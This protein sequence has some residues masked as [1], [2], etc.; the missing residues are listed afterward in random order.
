MCDNC[1]QNAIRYKAQAATE[2]GDCQCDSGEMLVAF[3]DKREFKKK[4]I[5]D[6]RDYE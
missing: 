1:G 6:W 2:V 3:N 4:D 5:T